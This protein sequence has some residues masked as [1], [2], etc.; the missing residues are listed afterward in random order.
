MVL[1]LNFKSSKLGELNVNMVKF[2]GTLYDSASSLYICKLIVSENGFPRFFLPFRT[3]SSKR[4]FYFEEFIYFSEYYHRLRQN[5][6][7]KSPLIHIQGL[8]L[9]W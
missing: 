1:K 3:Y 6:L 8:R 9:Q 4:N 7:P 2:T 5:M